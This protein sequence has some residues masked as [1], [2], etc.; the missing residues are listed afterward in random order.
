MFDAGLWYYLATLACTLTGLSWCR[1][2]WNNRSHFPLPPGPPSLPILGSILSFGDPTRPWLTFNS[3]RSTYGG[4][5]LGGIPLV[6]VH[7][8]LKVTSST[9][10]CS[11]SLSLWSTPRKSRETSLSCVPRY[12]LTDHC[13]LFMNRELYLGASNIDHEDIL[14]FGADFHMPLMPYG[15]R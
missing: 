7:V 5:N 1:K 15:N 8:V 2:Y 14:S 12:I 10:V 9:L 11:T 6:I 4:H 3:W 13:Q